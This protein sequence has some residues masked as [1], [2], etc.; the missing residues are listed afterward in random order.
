VPRPVHTPLSPVL[1]ELPNGD[2]YR[3]HPRPADLEGYLE[4]DRVPRLPAGSRTHRVR[5][6]PA[7]AGYT[8][9]LAPDE[10]QALLQRAQREVEGLIETPSCRRARATPPRARTRI[11]RPGGWVPT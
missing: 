7:G 9:T 5:V 8:V 11:P 2:R 3:I 4:P 10:L 6:T 1:L